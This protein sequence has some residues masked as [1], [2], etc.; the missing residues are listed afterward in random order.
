MATRGSLQASRVTVPDTLGFA[1]LVTVTV[2]VI[3]EAVFS[4]SVNT[5]SED[6]LELVFLPLYTGAQVS[7]LS[8]TV[9][10]VSIAI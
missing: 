7:W 2:A 5:Y 10:T 3:A 8:V 1:L 6:T 4:I 9:P